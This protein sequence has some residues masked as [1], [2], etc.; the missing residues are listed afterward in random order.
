[1]F[2][3]KCGLELKDTEKFC[4]RCGWSVQLDNLNHNVPLQSNQ[5]TPPPKKKKKKT[6][7]I[8]ALVTSFALVIGACGTGYYFRQPLSDFFGLNQKNNSSQILNGVSY[9]SDSYSSPQLQ[10][11]CDF[12]DKKIKISDFD[13]AEKM[14]ISKSETFGIKSSEE[15]QKESDTVADD[16]RFYSFT[17]K[18]KNIPIYG[19]K[20]TVTVGKDNNCQYVNY[21]FAD[22]S[23]KSVDPKLSSDDAIKKAKDFFSNQDELKVSNNGLCFLQLGNDY[24]LSYQVFANSYE[25]FV[26][27]ENGKILLA[28]N[29]ISEATSEGMNGKKYDLNL[30]G[31]SYFD[32]SR[33]ISLYNVPECWQS[34]D[35]RVIYDSS[36]NLSII[37]YSKKETEEMATTIFENVENIYD[38]YKS[39]LGYKSLDK[40]GAIPVNIYFLPSKVWFDSTDFYDNAF[41]YR[42][43]ENSG[44]MIV[45]VPKRNLN[46]I[47]GAYL[48]VMAHEYGH[49]IIEH[50]SKFRDFYPQAAAMNEA[51]ADIFGCCAEAIINKEDPDW[52]MGNDICIRNYKNL[53]D[54]K[55]S[56]KHITNYSEYNDSLDCHSACTLI[57]NIA[58]QSYNGLD[59]EEY[60]KDETKISDPQLMM[61]LWYHALKVLSTVSTFDDCKNAIFKAANEVNLTDAQIAGLEKAFSDAGFSVSLDA[62]IARL[63]KA[64]IDAEFSVSPDIVQAALDNE[65]TWNVNMQIQDIAPGGIIPSNLSLNCDNCWFQDFNMDGTP[66]FVTESKTYD[67]NLGILAKSYNVFHMDGTIFSRYVSSYGDNLSTIDLPFKNADTDGDYRLYKDKTSGK[68]VYLRQA[69][70]TSISIG[71]LE[72]LN[73]DKTAWAQRLLDVYDEDTDG[74]GCDL[75]TEATTPDDV[76]KYTKNIHYSDACTWFDSYK[77]NL[78]PYSVNIKKIKISDWNLMSKYA[79]LNALNDSYKAWSYTESSDN[80][81]PLQDV[82]DSIKIQTT[83]AASNAYKQ[84]YKDL[85]T[86]LSQNTNITNQFDYALYDMNQDSVPELIVKSGTCEADYKLSF[87]TYKNSEAIYVSDN[88]NGGHSNFYIDQSSNQFCKQYAQMGGGKI[89]WYSFDGNTVTISNSVNNIQY[90]TVEDIDAAF[91]AYGN[92]SRLETAHC[93]Y[94]T[95]GWHTSSIA[96]Q[97]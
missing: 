11:S 49:A 94:R 23:G 14:I 6:G 43:Q 21:N 30:N 95:D 51:F 19:S 7:R 10:K 26:D 57:S 77:T 89:E 18:Y 24:V 72:K 74:K 86:S 69:I 33:N 87:Y 27:A 4:K 60:T 58:Y 50:T 31:S 28:G 84:A 67:T 48:D 88:F 42:G 82:I 12:K 62:Q 5:Q 79:K 25:A 53:S 59:T 35:Q 8:V 65:S 61:K 52:V 76:P 78:T 22:L 41:Y 83:T 75:E 47:C 90:A 34:I 32:K 56:G 85:I 81:F 63:N 29:T 64:F 20:I 55:E 70:G 46:Q 2:C 91:A 36:N 1:M 68:F 40:E 44:E 15:L 93:Y 13:A 16:N 80:H 71:G 92:F 38:C 66:E 96:S 17:Q 39:T 45:A 97:K 37:P 73:L 3:K 54:S 9:V